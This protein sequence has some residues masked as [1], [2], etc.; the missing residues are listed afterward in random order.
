M[1][2]D[3]DG[4]EFICPGNEYYSELAFSKGRIDDWMWRWKPLRPCTQQ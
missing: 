4:I 2:M 3:F 1:A